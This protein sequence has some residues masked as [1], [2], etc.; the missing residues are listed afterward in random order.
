MPELNPR[1]SNVQAVRR[2]PSRC[3]LAS[4]GYRIEKARAG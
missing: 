2:Q 4:F 1:F 3:L